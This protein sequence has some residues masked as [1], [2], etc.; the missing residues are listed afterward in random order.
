MCPGGEREYDRALVEPSAFQPGTGAPSPPPPPPPAPA[1]PAG[2]SAAAPLNQIAAQIHAL[3]SRVQ[4][5]EREAQDQRAWR[6]QATQLLQDQSSPQPVPADA[7]E[8]ARASDARLEALTRLFE[9]QRAHLEELQEENQRLRAMQ[10]GE[11]ASELPLPIDLGDLPIVKDPAVEAKL[12]ELVETNGRLQAE[13]AKMRKSATA[14]FKRLK[15]DLSTIENQKKNLLVAL[16]AR[17]AVTPEREITLEEIT[18]SE[19][20][21][22]MLDNIKKTSREEVTLLHDAVVALSKIDPLAYNAV[23]PVVARTF[24]TAK[25]ENP[26]AKLRQAKV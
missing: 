26:L 17:D 16:A 21:K 24:E 1:P 5:L 8:H 6:A 3:L 13:L 12:R 14:K 11:E 19:V 15:D 18:A 2:P 9:E 25:V 7:P 4:V 22:T 10:K 20:F 23:L